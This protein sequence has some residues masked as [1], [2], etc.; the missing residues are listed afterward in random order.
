MRVALEQA[1]VW[2]RTSVLPLLLVSNKRSKSWLQPV[3]EQARG[4]KQRLVPTEVFD[5]GPVK[6]EQPALV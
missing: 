4:L 5:A 1:A 2:A 3:V 6:P